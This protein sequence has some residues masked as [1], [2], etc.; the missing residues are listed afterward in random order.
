MSGVPSCWGTSL[1]PSSQAQYTAGT[2]SVGRSPGHGSLC[3]RVNGVVAP[4]PCPPQTATGMRRCTSS[5]ARSSSWRSLEPSL[6]TAVLHGL[7]RAKG[8]GLGQGISTMNR[9]RC[10][11]DIRL[12]SC[13][14]S[15]TS[16]PKP[17]VLQ[18]AS[19]ALAA[20]PAQARSV[21]AGAR[22]FSSACPWACASCFWRWHCRRPWVIAFVA[23]PTPLLRGERHAAAGRARLLAPPPASVSASPTES[24]S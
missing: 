13:M 16:P 24:A 11:R 9:A 15:A 22:L 21:R 20:R 7:T 6:G 23:E 18:A 17:F 5:A 1:S 2:R 10:S 14:L 12:H 3:V 19:T 8:R 4:P